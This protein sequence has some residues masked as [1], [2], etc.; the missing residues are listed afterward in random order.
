VP[1]FSAPE[2]K[3]GGTLRNWIDDFPRTLRYYGPD[4]NGTFRSFILDDWSLGLIGRQPNTGQ[5]IPLLAR[6]WAYGSDKRT[7]YFR[8]DPDARYADGVPVR[9]DDYLFA[10]FFFTSPYLHDPFSVNYF[11][12]T[13]SG[14][15]KYDDLTIA[16]TA[17]EAKPDLEATVGLGPVPEHFYKELGDDYPERYQWRIEPTTGA[18]T[19]RPEDIHKGSSIDLTR[20]P[21]WWA[22]AKPFFRHRY[23]VDRIHLEVIR[24]TNKAF[25]AFKRGDVDLFNMKEPVHWYEQLPDG[26]PLVQRG[27]VA[28]AVFYNQ[29]PCPTYAFYVNTAQPLLDNHDIREGIASAANFDLVD[30]QYFHGDYVRMQTSADGY[31]QVPFPGIHPRP[32]S[33]ENAL[34]SFA[35]A[36]FSKR[37]PDG[38]LS[39]DQGQR[40]SFTVTSYHDFLRDPLTILRQ[41]AAKAGLELNIEILDGTT[42]VKKIME[43]HHQIA[44]MAFNSAGDLYP[45][46]YWQF[47]DSANAGKP[48]TNNL[49]NTADPEMDRLIAAYDKAETMDE[50]RR[51]ATE[52][53]V[54]IHDNA[55]FI[56]AYK[57]PLF[58][59][60]YWRWIKFPKDFATRQS[61]DGG[62][63]LSGVIGDSLFWIDDAARPAVLAARDGGPPASPEIKVYDQWRQK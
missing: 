10:F 53:E 48:Q 58:R 39:N 41:E 51:L 5:I 44:F 16:I 22:D 54:R 34:A 13:F 37:G 59:I 32:F 57:L 45:Q 38:I 11:Q 29:V 50:I 28:K 18:Y 27:A 42:G 17:R 31:P 2:A 43:K 15:A 49:T 26:D 61:D 19:V 62:A 23:N 35:K 40:L 6:E 55:A 60:A 8:L 63:E 25:E 14:V 56:P 47:F 20:V 36:G 1:E 3:R 21:N 9:A 4:A 24:D 12:K 30:Q 33:V 7:M 52:M 46:S